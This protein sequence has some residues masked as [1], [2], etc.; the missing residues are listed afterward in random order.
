VLGGITTTI[1]FKEGV[2]RNLATVGTDRTETINTSWPELTLQ[3]RKFTHLPFIK[4]Q[5]NWFIGVFSPRTGYSR[6]AKEVRNVDRDGTIN[7]SET[8]NRNPIISLNLKIFRR[9]SL[10]GAYNVARTI[11]EKFNRSTFQIDTETRSTKKTIAL[12]TKYAFSAPSG[13][14]IPLLG[15][16]KFKSMVS[17]DFNVQYASNMVETSKKGGDFVPFTNTSSFSASPVLSYSFSTKIRGGVTMRWQD[18]ND[19]QRHRVSHVRE[20]QIWTEIQF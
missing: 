16:L 10:S 14:S 3:I 18:T 17:I 19:A 11:D 12:S 5:V 1:G 15:K 8:I 13:L 7:R 4:K 20:V 2:S 6:Q 9:L